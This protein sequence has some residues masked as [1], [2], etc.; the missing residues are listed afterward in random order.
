MTLSEAIA[1]RQTHH[2]NAADWTGSC[3]LCGELAPCA[4]WRMAGEVVTVSLRAART[5]SP[6]APANA[7]CCRTRVGSVL[8]RLRWRMTLGGLR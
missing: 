8:R 5:P 1:I 7:Q 2:P 6:D 3:R 4:A